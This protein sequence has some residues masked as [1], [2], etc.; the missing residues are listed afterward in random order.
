MFFHS[1]PDITRRHS[2]N[3]TTRQRSSRFNFKQPLPLARR[4]LVL[5]SSTK[6]P[7]PPNCRRWVGG[8]NK[9]RTAGFPARDSLE[10]LGR[11]KEETPQKRVNSK[12]EADKSKCCPSDGESLEKG[13]KYA[14]CPN[15]VKCIRN[16]RRGAATQPDNH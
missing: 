13:C 10:L 16:K 4:Y 8:I 14:I 11:E 3:L 5:Y 15:R 7:P 2:R 12:E 1:A 6:L 9:G